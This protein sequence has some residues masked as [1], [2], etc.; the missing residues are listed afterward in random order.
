MENKTYEPGQAYEYQLTLDKLL[1][2]ALVYNPNQEI[3]YRDIIRYT[4]KD[5]MRRI[6]KL[7]N[8]LKGIGVK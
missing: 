2:A 1:K 8:V 7:A 3:V 5:L 4:Y 6:H